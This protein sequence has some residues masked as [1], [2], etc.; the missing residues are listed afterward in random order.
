MAGARLLLAGLFHIWGGVAVFGEPPPALRCPLLDRR[1]APSPRGALLRF[2]GGPGAPPHPETPPDPQNTFDVI[3][4]LGVLQ[5]FWGPSLAPPRCELSPTEPLLPPPPGPSPR[6]HPGLGTRWWLLALGTPQREGT[7]LLHQ[8]TT[9]GDT[10]RVNASLAISTLTP[11]LRGLLGTPQTLHCSFTPPAPGVPFTLEWLRHR[12]GATRRLLAFDSAANRV[13]E[14]AP[15]PPGGAVQVSLQLPPLSVSD[16]GSFICSVAT[17]LGQLQQVLHMNVIAPPQV[18][19]VPSVLSPGV[20]ARLRCDAVGFFP[21]DVGIRWERQARGD[22]RPRPVTPEGATAA[23]AP[24]DSASS[25][26]DSASSP[27]DGAAGLSWSSGHRR[28]ADGTFSRSAGL[29]VAAGTAGDSYSCLVTHAAWDAPLRVT[30]D[31][32]DIG[33][34]V[35]D[36]GNPP[37]MGFGD[38]SSCLVTHAAWDAPLRVTVQVAGDSGP[39]VEDMA[40]MAL[41]AFV[42]GGLCQRLWPSAG[43]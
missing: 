10:A 20:P 41:V 23:A 31:T 9:A 22:P 35:W 39:S 19:L 33:D 5:G 13:T 42:I 28:A 26:G 3:D 38:S 1:G 16:D 30:V 21:L 2:L 27:G 34:R 4:A 6:C 24:G 36:I 18:S 40:G 25:P 14:A 32:G 43:R 12:D 7:V 17:P 37:G 15:G 11:R 8:V 29:S